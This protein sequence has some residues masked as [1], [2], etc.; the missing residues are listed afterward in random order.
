MALGLHVHRSL[1]CYFVAQ[2]T[3]IEK[4]HAYLEFTYICPAILEVWIQAFV[5]VQA[6]PVL[7]QGYVP[8]KVT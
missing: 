2:L 8:E 4:G 3:W 7:H 5:Q 1:L 6:G